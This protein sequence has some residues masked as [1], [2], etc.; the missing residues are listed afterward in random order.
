MTFK[1]IAIKNFKRNIKKYLIY[2]LCNS[3]II[4]TFF[5]YS[6]L[7]F[8]E[9]L[10]TTSQIEKGVLQALIVPNVALGVFSLVFISYAHASFIRWRK[11]EF[12]IFMN[13]GMTTSDIIKIIIYENTIVALGSIVLGLLVGSVF[14]RLFFVIIT[15]LLGAK[16]ISYIIGFKNFI[17]PIIIFSGI[18]LAN[19]ITTIITAY[20]FEVI[21]L[22]KADRKVQSN[23]FSNPLLA[24]IGL[25][26]VVRSL[27]ILYINF[28]VITSNM[29]LE[30]TILISIGVYIFISQFGGFLIKCVNRSRNI[31]FNKLLFI[32]SVNNKFKQTKK[33][34]FIMSI[35]VA[36]IIFYIGFVLSMYITAEKT[37][38]NENTYHITYAELGDKNIITSDRINDIIVKNN[39]KITKH[40][41]AEFVIYYGTDKEPDEKII[42][43]DKEINKLANTN[44]NVSKGS[45]IFL[46]QFEDMNQ[47][48]KNNF[49]NFNLSFSFN[50][51]IYELHNEK[52]VFKAI[53][54]S[55]NY[56]YNDIMVLNQA[57]YNYI[58]AQNYCC[59]T[60]RFQLYNFNNWKDTKSIV[61]ELTEQLYMSNK[62]IKP[63]S[64]K[65]FND[66]EQELLKIAS[67]IGEYT[68]NRQAD[69]LILV[70][71]SYLG[72]FFFIA[73]AIVLF[74]KLLSDVDTDKRKFTSMYKIGITDEEITRQIGSE[75]KP[76][77]FIGPIIGITLAFAYTIIFNQ[78]QTDNLK[79]YTIYSNLTVSF[80]FLIIQVLYYFICKKIYC[81]EIL[82]DHMILK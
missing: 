73:V 46:N 7:I 4:A 20:R 5:M 11:K 77:F 30:N 56:Y 19:L 45:Y 72:V 9:K 41:T 52:N 36:V 63:A 71:S 62:S 14:S 57:D 79:K 51:R 24:I 60:G 54:R 3:F 23:R 38:V 17:F 61:D 70:T 59:E 55:N 34:I 12:G 31:Y 26:I 25:A 27:I 39:E 65:Y 64:P 76:L 47:N 40:K 28:T 53:F 32:T 44:F 2:Y 18:Y 75:L 13:L 80:I 37:A 6:V 29:L 1:D 22:L 67:P 81:D 78:D 15:R 69:I 16:G 66:M 8:N 35:L 49:K 74:L 58:K 43:T 21:K 42:M 82:E 10:W 50:S 68:Y 48:E 33:I